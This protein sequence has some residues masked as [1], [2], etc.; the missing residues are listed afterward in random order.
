MARGSEPIGR[1]K[2][3]V[4]RAKQLSARERKAIAKR[5]AAARWDTGN[6]PQAVCSSEDKP[7]RIAGVD[8]DRIFERFYKSDRSRADGGS[9]LGLSIAK[10][11]VE[12]HGGSLRAASAGLGRGATFTFTLPVAELRPR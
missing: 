3:G 5:A 10:H 9:G 12:A 6:L 11:I 8:L 4:A 1:A 7:L 2:G